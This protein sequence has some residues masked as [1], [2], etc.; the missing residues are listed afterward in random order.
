MLILSIKGKRKRCKNKIK[1]DEALLRE[2]EEKLETKGEEE[3]S[4]TGDKEKDNKEAKKQL[5]PIPTNFIFFITAGCDLC[6]T[7]INTFGLTYLTTSMFQMMRGLKYF[8]I[9]LYTDMLI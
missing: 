9:I 6:A 4:P 3:N 7:T 1:Q 8:C 5:P 2:S